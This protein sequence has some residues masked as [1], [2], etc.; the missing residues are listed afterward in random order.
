L[1][2]GH[3]TTGAVPAGRLSQ[4]RHLQHLGHLYRVNISFYRVQPQLKSFAGRPETGSAVA[5]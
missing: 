1:Q 4:N 3:D 5:I 2:S